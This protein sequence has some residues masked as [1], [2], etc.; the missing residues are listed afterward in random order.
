MLKTGATLGSLGVLPAAT[1]GTAAATVQ[2]ASVPDGKEFDNLVGAYYYGWYGPN[3]NGG[4]HWDG[5]LGT[6]D[7]RSHTP[8]LGEYSSHKQAVVDQHIEWALTHGI[9]WFN[10]TWWGPDGFEEQTILNHLLDSQHADKMHFSALYEPKWRDWDWPDF[11]EPGP[12]AALREDFQHLEDTFFDDPNW[13]HI[14]GRPVVYFWINRTFT[15]DVEGAFDDAIST[16]D[17][18]PYVIGDNVTHAEPFD[19]TANFATVGSDTSDWGTYIDNTR[20]RREHRLKVTEHATEQDYIPSVQPGASWPDPILDHDADRFREVCQIMAKAMDD[21]LQAAIVCSFNEWHEGSTLEPAEE[22]GTSAL[23]VVDDELQG[24]SANGGWLDGEYA[25]VR[26]EFSD[27]VAPADVSD[28]GDVRPLAFW[29]GEAR[30]EAADGAE[31]QSDPAIA[32]NSG[33][34]LGTPLGVGSLVFERSALEDADTLVLRGRGYDGIPDLEAD[35]SVNGKSMGTYSLGSTY[36][37]YRFPLPEDIPGGD[38]DDGDSGPGTNRLVS[39]DSNEL[40]PG[41]HLESANDDYRLYFQGTDGNLVLRDT[42]TGDALWA[43]HTA[44]DGATSLTLQG[45]GNLEMSTDVGNQVWASETAGSG[46]GELVLY[47]DGALVL[48]DDGSAVWSVNGDP[49][50]D[51]QAPT[52]SIDTVDEDYENWLRLDGSDSSDPDGGS[53]SYQWE[54]SSGE[55]WQDSS[56]TAEQPW[57]DISNTDELTATLTVTDDEGQTATAKRTFDGGASGPGTNKLVYGDSDTLSPNEFLESSNGDYRLYFQGSDGNLVLRDTSTGDAL[58]ASGTAGD[59][60][61]EV[62]LQGDGNLV[63]YTDGGESVWASHTAGS[64]ADELV[65]EDDGALVLYAD[66]SQVWSVND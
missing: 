11:S 24:A 7:G 51:G 60:G 1:S 53:V 26:F 43:S 9:N 35:V 13:L 33:D 66:G 32:G 61:S 6:A 14:D 45:D 64:G 18:E 65:L 2:Q 8:E 50:D 57:I 16:L 38:P 30:L 20:D 56:D 41:D 3:Y 40:E 23:E 36:Q 62:N 12:R 37:D 25:T 4:F 52:A 46:A 39:S 59:G 42:S 22:Y 54:I 58:W 44:G 5:D 15:G 55:F 47:D 21:D 49:S 10:C 28:S 29:L 34:W 19:A 17:T 27:V 63:M 48:Y 31:I